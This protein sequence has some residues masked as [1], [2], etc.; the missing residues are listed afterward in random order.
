MTV[1]LCILIGAAAAA[2]GWVAV[3]VNAAAIHL[4]AIADELREQAPTELN[5]I[6]GERV[7]A[8]R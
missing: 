1:V 5:P 2:L 7:R 3:G 8:R 4:G 6:T